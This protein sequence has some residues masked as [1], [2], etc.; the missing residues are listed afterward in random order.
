MGT[1]D[2][3]SRR[4]R[5][6][7]ARTAAA[8]TTVTLGVVAVLQLGFAL[9]LLPVTMAWGGSQAVLTPGLRVAHVVAA[10]V[11]TGFVVVTRR[12]AGLWGAPEPHPVPSWARV[13]CWIVGLYLLLNTLGNAVSSSAL[14]RA[15]MTPLAAL[16]ALG[17]LAVAYRSRRLQPR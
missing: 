15:V 5:D 8:V 10:I 16:A 13:G 6:P 11:L 9:G 7:V 3:T 4:P 2:S 12:A 14:E 1:Q 17:A